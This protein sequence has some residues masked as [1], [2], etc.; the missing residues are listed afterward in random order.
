MLFPLS[1][2]FSSTSFFQRGCSTQAAVPHRTWQNENPGAEERALEVHRLL[3]LKTPYAEHLALIKQRSDDMR[4]KDVDFGRAHAERLRDLHT[5]MQDSRREGR[6]EISQRI[7]E[8]ALR[9]SQSDSA[10]AGALKEQ[11]E[12]W[13]A[14]QAEMEARVRQMPKLMGDPPSPECAH[15]VGERDGLAQAI[16]ATT[17]VYYEERKT[18]QQRLNGRSKSMSFGIKGPP[19]DSV[20]QERKTAGLAAM[21]AL[22]RE[23]ESELNGTHQRQQARTRCE[24]QKMKEDFQA[25]LDH[26]T[27]AADELAARRAAFQKRVKEDAAAFEERANSRQKGW[28]GYKPQEKSERR[29][30]LEAAEN[31]LTT[32]R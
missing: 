31:A 10:I 12:A 4:R 2:S 24:R 21:T 17:K 7:E 8:H 30:H 25:H 3:S 18:Q 14:R 27:A 28:A 11:A 1:K 19:Q 16:Q 5:A 20:I 23:Y 9:R 22:Y 26:K 6:R 32:Q 29:I 15:R 13:R